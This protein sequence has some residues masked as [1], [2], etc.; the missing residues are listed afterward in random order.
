MQVIDN[1]PEGVHDPEGP[2]PAT[3]GASEAPGRGGLL[4]TCNWRGSLLGR[5]DTASYIATSTRQTVVLS[6]AGPGWLA[7]VS[8]HHQRAQLPVARKRDL[9]RR[10]GRRHQPHVRRP[11]QCSGG[12]GP[13]R[14]DVEGARPIG[15]PSGR[16][17]TVP[18]PLGF[19]T[20]V[21]PAVRMVGAPHSAAGSTHSCSRPPTDW[22]SS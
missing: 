9:H 15:Q 11:P 21:R 6:E 3:R 19:R 22:M 7:L 18:N 5:T 10:I 17:I 13:L 16:F 20:R 2:A 12:P 14:H 8:K 1:T 4:P